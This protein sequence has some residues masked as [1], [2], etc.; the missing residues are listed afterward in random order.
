[1]V[2]RGWVRL[3]STTLL[4]TVD[5]WSFPLTFELYEMKFI[6]HNYSEVEIKARN[7]ELKT[8]KSANSGMFLDGQISGQS[9]SHNVK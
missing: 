1:M 9:Y 4:C 3:M 8:D 6:K 2:E 7:M 5:I